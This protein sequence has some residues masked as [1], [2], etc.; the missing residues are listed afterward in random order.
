MTNLISIFLKEQS[1][2][3][4]LKAGLFIIFTVFATLEASKIPTGVA[5]Q[6]SVLSPHIQNQPA[7]RAHLQIFP[8]LHK[9]A[10]LFISRLLEQELSQ[11]ELNI[12][13]TY[14]LLAVYLRTPY[15]SFHC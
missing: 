1:Y 6:T 15:L 7:P 11:D 5:V 10:H 12:K 3:I 13:E 14:Q 9:L 8:L 4:F 2:F